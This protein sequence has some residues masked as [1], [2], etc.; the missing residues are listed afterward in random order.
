ME[1]IAFIAGPY[2]ISWNALVL[3][4]AAAAAVC[5]FLALYLN[6]S[7]NALAGFAAVPVSVAL[8]LLASRAV[9]WYCYAESY[10]SFAAA[11]TD[12]S[13]GG[14]ALLG[15][16]IGC[17]LATVLLRLFRLSRNLPEMLDCMCLAGSAGIALGRMAS[18][19][20]SSD[21]GQMVESIRTMP[22]VYPVT[23]VTSGATEYRLATFLLQAMVAGILFL[24][25]TVFYLAGK[26]RSLKDGD[27][28]LVFLMC[29]G[30]SQIV[31]DSTRYDS[32]YFRSNGFVSIVQVLGAVAL[33]LSIVV[34][35][36]RLVKARKFKKWYLIVWAVMAALIGCAG[37][38][39]YHVQRHGNEA[40]FAYSVM[41]IC[42]L[43]VVLLTLVIRHGAENSF[44]FLTKRIKKTGCP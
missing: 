2:V 4:L 22:W 37:Y 19:F 38:M 12:Y 27:T 3:T 15:G 25:L 10:D 40:V 1:R 44:D 11:I 42:L 24:L 21:R 30:A 7:G 33:V 41:S 6:Q 23:N 5:V 13:S 17:L 35:S 16:F 31:L 36:V 34:F 28:S 20:N 39:E 29:Y 18:L 26:R 9:H 32:M 43:L 14:Y 8:S